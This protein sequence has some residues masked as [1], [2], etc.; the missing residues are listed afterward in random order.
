MIPAP[1]MGVVALALTSL[2]VRFAST[3]TG[4]RRLHVFPQRGVFKL[5]SYKRGVCR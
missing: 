4:G 1:E 2:H 5:N 3:G